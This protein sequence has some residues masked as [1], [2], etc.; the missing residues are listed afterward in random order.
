MHVDVSLGSRLVYLV[1]PFTLSTTSTPGPAHSSQPLHPSS[2]S[3]I[4]VPTIDD[5]PIIPP[6]GD[7]NALSGGRSVGVDGVDKAGVSDIASGTISPVEGA[8]GDNI[9]GIS[10]LELL[11][12]LDGGDEGGGLRICNSG[13]P[14]RSDNRGG[15]SDVGS[16]MKF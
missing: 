12:T 3:T 5:I 8:L 4:D 6:K 13:F 14:R 10:T 16:I 9:D 11:I 7:A 1:T 2:S 15:L